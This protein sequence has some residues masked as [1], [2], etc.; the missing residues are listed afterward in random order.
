MAMRSDQPIDADSIDRG[1]LARLKRDGALDPAELSD[2]HADA[3]NR[4]RGKGLIRDLAD[5]RIG[6][7]IAG[8]NAASAA[9]SPPPNP[10][11]GVESAPVVSDAALAILRQLEAAGGE[12]RLG[13]APGRTVKQLYDAGLIERTARGVA[14][15]PAGV[16][17]LER[18]KPTSQQVG[19]GVDDTP[20]AS[21]PPPPVELDIHT[22]AD[23][24]A[25]AAAL[26]LDV[27]AA[28]PDGVQ[29]VTLTADQLKARVDA[30]GALGTTPVL[31]DAAK[32]PHHDGWQRAAACPHPFDDA[33]PCLNCRALDFLLEHAPA[34]RPIYDHVLALEADKA[35][36][37][38]W[39]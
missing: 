34:L 36:L 26:A 13:A 38:D 9:A 32:G 33:M 1:I 18:Q 27:A 6:I 39:R 4:L 29:P 30:L 8:F 12:K 2:L 21:A 10:G 14:L 22:E 15:T 16:Q 28:V 35:R 3:L 20:P 7:S 17:Y 23:T 24:P 11:N 37:A 5:G 19:H 31:D 25:E